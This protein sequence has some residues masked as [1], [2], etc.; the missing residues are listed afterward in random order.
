[1]EQQQQQLQEQ[2]IFDATLSQWM[3]FSNNDSS[4]ES[5]A[6]HSSVSC[7]EVVAAESYCS[8][9]SDSTSFGDDGS[10]GDV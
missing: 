5:S 2:A 7:S 1:M 8:D 4:S 3:L 10:C 9:A 6:Q